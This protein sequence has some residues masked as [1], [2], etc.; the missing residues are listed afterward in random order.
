MNSPWC[1]WP[2]LMSSANFRP[3][4]SMSWKPGRG[5]GKGCWLIVSSCWY[6]YLLLM[7][8]FSCRHSLRQ[9]LHCERTMTMRMTRPRALVTAMPAVRMISS[10]R[11][12]LDEMSGAKIGISL[13]KDFP[14][15]VNTL[16]GKKK[17][18]QRKI[19]TLRG[20][21]S[22]LVFHK[23][24]DNLL[25]QDRNV[26]RYNTPN[27]NVVYL[28]ILMYNIITHAS[29]LFPRCWGMRGNKFSREK[30]GFVS[31]RLSHKSGFYRDWHSRG[32]KGQASVL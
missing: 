24:I 8:C 7:C 23:I 3:T 20:T 19:R 21:F 5:L 4:V 17:Y 14:L 18:A 27:H 1:V 26:S 15:G 16:R 30:I 6:L 25:T 12:A 29:D 28:E 13:K 11:V 9:M 22:L 2:S 31:K 10:I 32:Q